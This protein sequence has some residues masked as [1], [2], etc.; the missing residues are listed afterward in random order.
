M[1]LAPYPEPKPRLS[2]FASATCPG[3]HVASRPTC[4]CSCAIA[5]VVAGGRGLPDSAEGSQLRI[6]IH[7]GCMGPGPL[8][9]TLLC[10]WTSGPLDYWNQGLL[11][12][13][14]RHQLHIFSAGCQLPLCFQPLRTSFFHAS[15]A[16]YLKGFWLRCTLSVFMAT[17]SGYRIGLSTKTGSPLFRLFTLQNVGF[18][19]MCT[20]F[21]F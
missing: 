7:G 5:G 3:R 10:G 11:P 1:L 21:H 12:G 6:F 16:M 15:S 4:P 8:F 14:W 13:K 19:I 2:H 17:A 20:I 18:C 9:L